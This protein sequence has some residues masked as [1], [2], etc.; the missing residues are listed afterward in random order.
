MCRPI[1]SASVLPIPCR[2]QR[3]RPRGTAEHR[4]SAV[5]ARPIR[6]EG[7]A[8]YESDLLVPAA[9]RNLA[10]DILVTA[11]LP[12]PTARN[13]EGVP[14]VPTRPASQACLPP[15]ARL[16]RRAQSDHAHRPGHRH[17]IQ[18]TA[19]CS[20]KNSSAS[21]AATAP[22]PSRSAAHYHTPPTPSGRPPGS[23]KQDQ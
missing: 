14:D 1:R 23:P 21:S 11:S 8:G 3:I 16:Y 6:A 13:R 10:L 19:G 18:A 12:P 20:V 9:M 17:W 15:Q 7:S 4:S 22:S 2:W 5:L